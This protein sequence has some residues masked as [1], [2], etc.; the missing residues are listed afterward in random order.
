MDRL[1]PETLPAPEGILTFDR[2]MGAD[3]QMWSFSKFPPMQDET[4][5]KVLRTPCKVPFIIAR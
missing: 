2:C 5:K 1:Q 3:C 4:A